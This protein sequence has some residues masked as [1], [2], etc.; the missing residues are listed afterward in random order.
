MISHSKKKGFT[1][2]ELVIV[3]TLAVVV[4]GIIWTMFTISNKI[5]SDVIIKSD[6]QREGQAIQEKL[7]NSGMQ[8]IGIQPANEDSTSVSGDS[9]TKEINDIVIDLNDK[10]GSPYYLKI[11]KKYLGKTYI[12]TIK[13]Y[14]LYIDDKLISSNLKSMKVNSE[15]IT[16]DPNKNAYIQFTIILSKK[17]TYNNEIINYPIKIMTVFRNKN[18]AGI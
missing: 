13:I 14:E 5:I 17:K 9:T 4:L 11:E 15:I 18:T 16:N 7:S 8:A 3:M 6:L 10:N 1:V 2:M 12:D